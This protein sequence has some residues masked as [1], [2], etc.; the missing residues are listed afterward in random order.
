VYSER[1][2]RYLVDLATANALYLLSDGAYSD[3]QLDEPFQSAPRFDLD[4]SNIIVCNSLSKNL[5]ISG[6]RIGYV[7]ARSELIEQILKLNQ[8]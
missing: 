1:E 7:V 8:M 5:G 2:I 4:K 6:W 3:F